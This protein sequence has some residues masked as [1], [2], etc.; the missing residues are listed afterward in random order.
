MMSKAE[1]VLKIIKELFPHRRKIAKF[2]KI[3][4][5]GKIVENLVFEEEDEL[6]YLTKNEVVQVNEY[7]ESP[8]SITLP[9]EVVKHFIKK[10]NFIWK[11]DFCICR[12]SNECENYPK[13]LGCLFMGEAAKKISP[14]YGHPV[15]EKEALE[16]LEKCREAGLVHMIGRNKLDMVWLD[17]EPGGKLLS[18]C[19]CCPCCCIGN[20]VPDGSARLGEKYQK[21]P[22]VEVSVTDECVGCGTCSD[23]C[24]VDA[25]KVE[26]GKAKIGEECKGC[27][28]CV[29]ICPNDAIKLTVEDSEFLEKSIKRIEK[30]VDVG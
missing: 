21:M 15:S 18:V 1:S 3:P 22:G 19:N 11:M 12:K 7:I 20:L 30:R 9:S 26:D 27:G 5:F 24:F 6:I 23:I 10:A 2:T 17:V 4:L 13:D 29:D 14:E 25:I 16:H 28:R 8:E